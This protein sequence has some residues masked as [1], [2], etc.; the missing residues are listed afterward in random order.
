MNLSKRKSEESNNPKLKI[1][2]K[3][4]LNSKVGNMNKLKEIKEF[5]IE[6]SPFKAMELHSII[7]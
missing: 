7:I 2:P 4:Q 3:N 1:T 5:E 6:Q